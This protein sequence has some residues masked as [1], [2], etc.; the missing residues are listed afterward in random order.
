MR[1]ISTATALAVLFGSAALSLGAAGT[2]SAAPA[3][4]VTSPGGLAVDGAAQR[5]FVGDS[6]N[7]TVTATDYSGAVL[8]SVAGVT[9]VSDLAVSDDG[10]TVYAAAPQIHE[11]WAIDAN[12][13]TVKARYTVATNTGP[14]YVAF[15]GGKVWF[16]YGDQWD[17]DLGSVDPSVDP[18]SGTDP[19]SLEQFPTEGTSVGIWGQ[20]LLDT[21]PTQ[22]GILGVAET[23]LS[24]DSMAVLDVSS[25]KAALVAW[26]NGDYSLNNGI[27]DIDLVP[28]GKQ[29]LVNG[30]D[31]DAYADGTFKAAG[32]YPS[33]QFAD[34]ASNGLVAQVN[35]GKIMTYQPGATLPLR[36]YDEGTSSTADLAWAPDDSRIFALVGSPAQNAGYTLKV[37]TGP[38]LNNPTLTVNAPSSATRAKQ[39]T[40]TG[41]LSATVPLPT[42][43]KLQVT[44]VDLDSPS[45]KALPAVTV[46]TDGTY[47]FTDTPSAGGTVTYKVT[48]AGDAAHSAVT[49]SDKVDVSRATASL[50]LNNNGK[51]YSYGAD[52]KFT[53]H[54]GTT[55]KNRTVEI[56]ANPYGGDKPNKLLKSGKVDSHGNISAT[57]DMTRDTDV[58][59]VFKGDSRYKPR[60]VKSTGYAKVKTSTAVTKYYKTA[61]IGSTTYYWFHK[62]TDPLLTTTMTYY[63][64]RMQRM[65]LQ[66]YYGGKWYTADGSPEYFKL[67]SNGKSAV[68]LGAPGTSGIKARMRSSYINNSSGDNVNTTTYG[69]WKYLYFSN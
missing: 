7:G 33:G 5:V 14:R 37:L 27:G 26:H 15:S 11:I 68:S 31:R 39:L 21:D 12:T 43:A 20:A 25:G 63:P 65:D 32:S 6:T 41:R 2:A 45:G 62:N 50:S 28:G 42:G 17:G 29:V 38:A 1:S 16:S 61:K 23:G 67:A 57:V 58:T 47:S 48:Y 9:G 60:T 19:V 10:A 52:V 64:G 51:V 18:A 46:R 49:A 30:R 34:V 24:S 8:G 56:W 55:Y 66:V 4:H 13:L 36:T 40:V 53:A 35:G 22:P 44:R 54:L 59:A 3:A 69:S